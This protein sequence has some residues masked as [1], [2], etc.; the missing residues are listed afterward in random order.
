[1]V[2]S[3]SAPL[4]ADGALLTGGTS[5]KVTVAQA[6][7]VDTKLRAI[8]GDWSQCAWGQG[9]EI[10]MKVSDVASFTDENSVVRHAFQENLVVLLIEAYY[11]FVVGNPNA[12]VAYT[13]AA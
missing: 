4:S 13:D 7:G 5:P 6:T 2:G 11:G 1:V 8:G 3:A 10:T 12:F 9:M